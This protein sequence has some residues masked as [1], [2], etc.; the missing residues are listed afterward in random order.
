[1]NEKKLKQIFNRTSKEEKIFKDTVDKHP[2][3]S[4]FMKDATE[5][6]SI[7]S[8]DEVSYEKMQMGRWFY[9]LKLK[10]QKDIILSPKVHS[11]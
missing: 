5:E 6:T 2:K 1:M 11:K 8:R 3:S 7:S 10:K 4:N 9:L